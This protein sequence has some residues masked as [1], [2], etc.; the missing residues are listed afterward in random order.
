MLIGGIEAGG[1]KF[2]YGIANE[3]GDII[4]RLSCPTEKPEITLKT[5]FDYFASKN[6][7]ALGIASFGPIDLNKL[8]ET[9]GYITTT[10]KP[11][12][13]NTDLVGAFRRLDVPIAFDTDVNGAALAE[14]IW[15]ASLGLKNSIYITV[16]TGIGGGIITEGNIVHGMLHPE[17]GHMLIR[18]HP[19]DNFEGVCPFHKNCLEGMASGPS[20][21][22][23]WSILGK[24]QELPLNHKAW[25]FEAYYLAQALVNIILILA[26]EKI[27]LGGGVMNEKHLFPKIRGYVVELLSGYLNSQY[28]LD[29]IDS[30]I[31]EPKLGNNAGLLGAIA[32]GKNVT[33]K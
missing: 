32:L 14:S 31:V 26:P 5:V 30:Y 13:Q 18:I 1:T 19:E 22:K 33:L 27:I 16:G 17:I 28:I 4:E 10:P 12:W 8:S 23:R 7:S 6:I 24:H 29:D 15:G 9:Y 3:N 2:V 20:F 11:H 21:N 25:D